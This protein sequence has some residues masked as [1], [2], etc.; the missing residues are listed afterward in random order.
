MCGWSVLL[1]FLVTQ[2]DFLHRIFK[3]TDLTVGQWVLC[4]VL[5][6]L[7]LWTTEIE[8]F[9]RR[10]AE[11]SSATQPGTEPAAAGVTI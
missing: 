9:F 3:T 7:V 6:S 2:L 1:V 5:G 4:M 10:R 8:K 11:A